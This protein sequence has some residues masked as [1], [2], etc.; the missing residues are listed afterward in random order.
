MYAPFFSVARY[1]VESDAELFEHVFHG[2]RSAARAEY[3][4]L[5]GA[6][7]AQQI[8]QR[9]AESVSVGIVTGQA[10]GRNLYAVHR[11]DRPCFV[12]Q[13]GQIRDDRLFIRD[14]DIESA[15]AGRLQYGFDAFDR[16]DRKIPVGAVGDSCGGEFIG[17][18]AL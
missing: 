4:R 2:F 5:F 16:F 6:D 7:V 14:R 18:I 10:F 17:K 3:E 8:Q 1:R 15:Q 9:T 12:A 11:A 13:A